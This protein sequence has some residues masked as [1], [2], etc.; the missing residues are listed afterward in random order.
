MKCETLHNKLIFF[1]EGDLTPKEE[2]QIK[3]HLAECPECAG[4]AKYLKQTLNIIQTE[5]LPEVNP[6]F[7]TRLKSKLE[8]QSI[9]PTNTFPFVLWKKILQPAFFSLLLLAGIYTGYKIGEEG[10]IKDDKLSFNDEQIVP[11]LNEMQAEPIETF[12]MEE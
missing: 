4:F 2:E 6:F 7:Y 11:Y 1:L 12:L 8:N 3:K 5:R 9:T 10:I